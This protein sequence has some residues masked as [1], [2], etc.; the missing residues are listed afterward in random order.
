[1]DRAWFTKLSL[2][3][4]IARGR[5]EGVCV[6]VYVAEAEL[7]HHSI[8]VPLSLSLSLRAN[9]VGPSMRSNTYP[10]PLEG[11][12]YSAPDLTA[13]LGSRTRKIRDGGGP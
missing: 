5:G 8:T 12:S 9:D 3:H 7:G 10:R 6:C 13:P 2:L 1:M 4:A 11:A